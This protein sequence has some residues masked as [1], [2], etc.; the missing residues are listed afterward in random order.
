MV[1]Q[2]ASGSGDIAIDTNHVSFSQPFKRSPDEYLPIPSVIKI[3]RQVLPPHVEILDDSKEMMQECVSEF[4]AFVTRAAN[5]KCHRDSRRIIKP[6]DILSA[7]GSIGFEYYVQPLTIFLKKYRSDSQVSETCVRPSFIPRVP[8]AMKL[9]RQPQSQPAIF[10]PEPKVIQPTMSFGHAM[11][12]TSTIDQANANE[13]AQILD[14][15]IN[16]QS[17]QGESICDGSLFEPYSKP[18]D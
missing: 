12:S 3:M 13:L 11:P 7:L 2:E 5:E 1:S 18:L 9:A 10:G 16:N 4:I 8:E 6:E 17:A 15:L 14:Y